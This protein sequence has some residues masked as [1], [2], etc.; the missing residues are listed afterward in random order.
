MPLTHMTYRK[1][2][3]KAIKAPVASKDCKNGNMGNKLI[4]TW[5]ENEGSLLPGIG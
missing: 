5:Y 4:D 3:V 1:D 2:K